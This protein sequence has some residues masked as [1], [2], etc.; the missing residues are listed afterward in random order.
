[1]SDLIMIN[2]LPCLTWN[3]LDLNRAAVDS[4]D[5]E[6]NTEVPVEFLTL[7][8]GVSCRPVTGAAAAK[9]L[10]RTPVQVPER[11]QAGK[12]PIYHP[13]R[14]ATGLG[15][16]FDRLAS[17]AADAAGKKVQLLEVR[18]GAAP[19]RPILWHTEYHDGNRALS[20]QI[21][22]VGEGAS[23]TLVMDFVSGAEDG[24]MAGVS[25][26][27]ILDRGARLDLCRVQML[28]SSYVHFDDMGA[29][30][31]EEAA[32]TYRQLELGG[33]RTY[34]G[35]QAELIGRR[36]SF[37]ARMGY[38]ATETAKMDIGYNVVQ[39][40][41][42]TKSDMTFDGTL[43]GHAAKTFRGTIDFR[44][45]SA[46]STGDE[47]E[48]VLLL[49]PAI[50]NKTIPVILCEEED[51]QGRHGATVGRLADD[52]LFYFGT[53]GVGMREAQEMMVTARLGAVAREIPDEDLRSRIDAFISGKI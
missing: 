15:G 50:V 9:L 44:N 16:D 45:G 4:R 33:S 5:L 51:V 14:F 20:R 17:A 12:V 19:A 8:D 47:Q 13:Q 48:N 37:T 34:A 30:L 32:M 53:R 41:R 36:S 11:V 24:G 31:G 42:R 6:V 27:V 7:P 49:S 52:I 25:T 18:P 3:R 23:L 29:S 1:M 26:G 2:N 35:A 28:G 39:R 43:A 38:F 21:I 10:A 22:H 46:G 40:G